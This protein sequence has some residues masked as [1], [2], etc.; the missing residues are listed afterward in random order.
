MYV[1]AE[2][3]STNQYKILLMASNS[4]C[5]F[6]RSSITGSQRWE[7]KLRFIHTSLPVGFFTY[8]LYSQTINTLQ[9]TKYLILTNN[10]E[11]CTTISS[12]EKRKQNV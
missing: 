3:V 1:S 4:G 2:T 9:F 8:I 12:L 6:E 10:C 11:V 5:F 7:E